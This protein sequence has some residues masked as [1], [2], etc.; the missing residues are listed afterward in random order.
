MTTTSHYTG[1]LAIDPE[2]RQRLLANESPDLEG[3]GAKTMAALELYDYMALGVEVRVD[4]EE[5]YKARQA[6]TYIL[7]M[8][9][10]EISGLFCNISAADLE[11]I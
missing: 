5:F 2:L 9:R 4:R 8:H 6:A 11:L 1:T 7:G 3:I 10:S